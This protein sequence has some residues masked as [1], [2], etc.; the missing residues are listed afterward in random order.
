MDIFSPKVGPIC[1]RDVS[2]DCAL[3]A[4]EDVPV[5]P[6][7]SPPLMTIPPHVL[8]QLLTTP[9][10]SSSSSSSRHAGFTPVNPALFSAA[11]TF[12]TKQ[13]QVL[14]KELRENAT[15][16]RNILL[17]S[18]S[19]ATSQSGAAVIPT[20]SLPHTQTQTINIQEIL[21]HLKQPS[22]QSGSA[23]NKKL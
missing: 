5:V 17:N 15:T 13:H 9:T 1:S 14:G 8:S 10:S 16:R 6:A 3:P 20:Y 18:S 12:T 19:V 22:P 21:A 2:P 7:S 11:S 23:R 4:L